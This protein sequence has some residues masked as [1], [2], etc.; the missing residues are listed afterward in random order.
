MGLKKPA[1]FV[2]GR[3]ITLNGAVYLPGAAVANAVVKTIKRLDALLSNGS[4]VANVDPY[5]RKKRAVTPS[6]TSVNPPT[7]AAL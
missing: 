7:K 6:P 4:L 3:K 2:A 1:S 5:N